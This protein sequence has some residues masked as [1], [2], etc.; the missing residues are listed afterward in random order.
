M[1]RRSSSSFDYTQRDTS[2]I[3]SYNLLRAILSRPLVSPLADRRLYHPLEYTR[4]AETIGRRSARFI[5]LAPR[6]KRKGFAARDVF[7]FND[8]SRVFVCARRQ[9]RKEVM[10][11]LGKTG[12]GAR[13]SSR[14]R[15]YHTEVSCRS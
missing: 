1:A 12:K 14:R 11:A 5:V 3:A 7:R 15:N 4:P 2:V 9:V 10:F 6:S 8:P 13:A